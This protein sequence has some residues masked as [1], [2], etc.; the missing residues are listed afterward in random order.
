M[1]SCMKKITF[2]LLVLLANYT[3]Y[4]QSEYGILVKTIQPPAFPNGNLQLVK[5][6]HS[7]YIETNSLNLYTNV[8]GQT[9]YFEE[10]WTVN[11]NET[12]IDYSFEDSSDNNLCYQSGT[13]NWNLL[14]EPSKIIT[15]CI[16]ETYLY[17]IHV[18]STD[19]LKS[20]CPEDVIELNNGWNWQY[21]F[22][23]KDWKDFA[24][25]FQAQRSISF[26]I[27]ELAGFENKTKVYFQAGFGTQFTNFLP[28]DISPCTPKI[29]STSAP[30]LTKCSYSND[31]A[32]TFTFER[33]LQ[34][35]EQ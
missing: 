25:N 29:V 8:L 33:E 21:S 18:T 22:D 34:D 31:G 2:L 9:Q 24:T 35:G 10:F 16:A 23:G 11:N 20:K 12:D 13:I 26:K 1:T 6:N 4:S 27:N 19:A 28:F 7:I 14:T 5:A 32:V 15:G 3:A 30:N 17:V